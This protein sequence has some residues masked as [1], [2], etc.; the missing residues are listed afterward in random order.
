MDV[1]PPQN[2]AIGYAP[3]PNMCSVNRVGHQGLTGMVSERSSGLG[4]T[5]S[6]PRA[7]RVCQYSHLALLAQKPFPCLAHLVPKG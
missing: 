5:V 1:H 4:R 3:W 7:G 2:G 6:K